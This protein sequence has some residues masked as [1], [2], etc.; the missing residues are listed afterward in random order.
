MRGLGIVSFLIQFMI[1]FH[2][3]SIPYRLVNKEFPHTHAATLRS[4][5]FFGLCKFGAFVQKG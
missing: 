5:F 2:I 3:G 4:F 1:Q